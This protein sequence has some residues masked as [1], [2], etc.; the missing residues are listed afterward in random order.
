MLKIRR[1]YKFWNQTKND[2]LLL[3]QYLDNIYDRE[4]ISSLKL[5]CELFS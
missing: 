2:S 3:N 1:K 5:S 4:R